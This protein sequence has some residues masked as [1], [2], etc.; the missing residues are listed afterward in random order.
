MPALKNHTALALSIAQVS[1]QHLTW[2]SLTLPLTG[3]HSWSWLPG[4]DLKQTKCVAFYVNKSVVVLLNLSCLSW[5]RTT[6][7]DQGEQS[8]W[9]IYSDLLLNLSRFSALGQQSWGS[10]DAW[11][12]VNLL[13]V[14]PRHRMAFGSSW[15]QCLG[16]EYRRKHEEQK[17]NDDSRWPFGGHCS[18]VRLRVENN[19]ARVGA[20]GVLMLDFSG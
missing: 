18:T 4:L 10:K 9:Q 12:H 8:I 11:N 5:L 13:V 14:E 15:H 20:A 17:G 16:L 19:Y 1:S 7:H 2:S 6:M 3:I